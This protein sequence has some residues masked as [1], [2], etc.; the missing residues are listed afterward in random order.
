MLVGGERNNVLAFT[1]PVF[2]D[3]GSQTLLASARGESPCSGDAAR[4]KTVGYPQPRYLG[5]YNDTKWS[6]SDSVRQQRLILSSNGNHWRH[7]PF[8]SLCLVPRARSCGYPVR[9]GKLSATRQGDSPRV[10]QKGPEVTLPS[11][12][13]W[14]AQQSQNIVPLNT[15]I[16]Q[17]MLVGVERNNVAQYC[18]AGPLVSDDTSQTQR[19]HGGRRLCSGGRE[20]LG[21][22]DTHNAL[23][24]NITLRM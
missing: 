14:A 2:S 12:N 10:R 17:R 3:N 15:S 21:R 7:T 1:N 22:R 20:L 18:C 4:S 13:Q 19:T 16:P 6:A 5:K 24:A 23:S 9:P 11:L 8:V